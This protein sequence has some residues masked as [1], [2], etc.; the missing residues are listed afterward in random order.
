MATINLSNCFPEGKD[1]KR[2]PLPK[3]QE[4]LKQVM[5]PKGAKFVAYYGGVG[6]GKSLIL[7]VTMLAQGIAHGGSWVIARQFM[8]ELRR[9]TYKQFK[10]ILPKE[11]IIE[12]RIADAEITIKAA[13]GRK[14]TFYFVGLDDAD[15]LRSLNLSGFGIDEASQVSEDAFLILQSRLRHQHGLRKG[16]LVGNPA[17]RDWVYRYFVA[18]NTF[19]NE[20]AKKAYNLVLAP[21][22]ENVHLPEG[23]IEAML[24]T[25]SAERIARDIMGSFDAFEGQVYSEFRRDT[26]VIQ[27]FKIPDEWEKVMGID[28]GFRNPA[29]ALWAAVNYDGDIYI[30]REYYHTEQ[31]IEQIIKGNPKEGIKGIIELCGS[32]KIS[33]CVID[34]S[35]AATRG[36]TGIS[37][38]DTYLEH[39]PRKFPLRPA[40]NTVMAGIDRVKSYLKLSEKTKKPRIYI[41]NTCVNLIEEI[42]QYKWK[43]LGSSSEGH[44]NQPEEVVKKDDHAADALR[45]IIMSRPELPKVADINK[46]IRNV[47]GIE[48]SLRREIH[49]IK[50]RGSNVDPL[51]DI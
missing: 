10:E 28:H 7:C 18:K 40:D 25:Y 43:P 24:S 12:D 21:S 29:A 19:S 33:D 49:S 5:D 47:D 46:K 50:H 4:F 15:K 8:P 14:A 51:S 41:F 42:L 17:G 27:P 37:D 48:G 11:L 32:E 6:S 26:H 36:Q 35:T 3:Q 2:G 13:S 38:F 34:P 16:I 9:T 1:G 31:L 39:L 22:T 45:Y 44:K 30:Y 23:Y 20:E